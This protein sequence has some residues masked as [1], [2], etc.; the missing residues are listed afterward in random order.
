MPDQEPDGDE[1]PGTTG[2][3][4]D[5][6]MPPEPA[7]MGGMREV[8]VPLGALA[9]PD[10]EQQAQPPAAGDQVQ[11]NAEGKVTR[12]DGDNAYVEL[13]HVNGQEVPEAATT[14][15][16]T[17]DQELAGLEEEAR[18]QPDRYA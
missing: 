14:P 15:A 11:F 17:E 13:S 4:M 2:E 1:L 5:E 3:T 18:N 6:G 8:C 9:M 7:P 10:E 16:P 12:I